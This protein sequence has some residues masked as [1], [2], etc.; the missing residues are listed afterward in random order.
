MDANSPIN[1]ETKKATPCPI[2]PVQYP[3]LFTPSK[4]SVIT[5][6][7]YTVRVKLNGLACIQEGPVDEPL[8]FTH[9]ILHWGENND[10]G[11]EHPLDCE[12]YPLEAQF[13]F[14]KDVTVLVPRETSEEI[15]AAKKAQ[16][17]KEAWEKKMAECKEKAEDDPTIDCTEAVPNQEEE[18]TEVKPPPEEPDTLVE[19]D[20]TKCA[21]ASVLFQ[22]D[23]SAPCYE[24]FSYLSSVKEC[25]A[26][27]MVDGNLLKEFKCALK[28]DDFFTYDG[29][30]TT[31]PHPPCTTWLIYRRPLPIRCTDMSKLRCLRN[32][33][34]LPIDRNWKDI[35]PLCD[36]NVRYSLAKS[37]VSCPGK[38]KCNE[39]E[40]CPD[41]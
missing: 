32:T 10:T 11:C 34:G 31:P 30:L 19:K 18:T 27:V 40:I 12:R 5:N 25:G 8:P 29:T 26:Q 35:Q 16:E 14:M 6:D 33:K 4:S 1:I 38:E 20:I 28:P 22:I 3:G 7:G 39:C 24:L 41:C 15:E 13:I 2:C 17:E 9:M 23:E 37:G 21:V 36:R